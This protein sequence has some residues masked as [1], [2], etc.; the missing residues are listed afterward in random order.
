M[1]LSELQASIVKGGVRLFLVSTVVGLLFALCAALIGLSLA[2]GFASI[3]WLTGPR[4][5]MTFIALVL[6]PAL[7]LGTYGFV[8]TQGRCCRR[9]AMRGLL[10]GAALLSTIGCGGLLIK[11][12]SV[13]V[14]ECYGQGRVVAEQYRVVGLAAGLVGVGFLSSILIYGALTWNAHR[15]ANRLRSPNQGLIR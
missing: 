7:V 12:A 14:S 2:S 5:G 1:K 9:E 13:L 15:D 10:R 8:A 3:G 4:G 11:S 6:L